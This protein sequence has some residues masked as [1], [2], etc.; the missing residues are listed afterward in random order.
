MKPILHPL[1]PVPGPD[2]EALFQV[3]GCSIAR[4]SAE[5]LWHGAKS[6]FDT[7]GFEEAARLHVQS[8]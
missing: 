5:F 2:L 3:K 4:A 6:M 7:V 8:H 1:T